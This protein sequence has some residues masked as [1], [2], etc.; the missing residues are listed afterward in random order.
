MR[1]HTHTGLIGCAPSQ[2][3]LN[4][5]NKR[6]CG[7]IDQLSERVPPAAY[8]PNPKGVLLGNVKPGSKEHEK[9]AREAARTVPPREHGMIQYSTSIHCY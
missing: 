1:T 4:T 8:P 6:E 9:I 3:L 7:L 2:E 5:W